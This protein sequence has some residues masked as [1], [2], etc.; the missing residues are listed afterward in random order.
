MTE[1]ELTYSYVVKNSTEAIFNFYRQGYLYYRIVVK[2]GHDDER[3]YVF[4][5]E[6]SDLGTATTSLSEKPLTMMRYIRKSLED[7]TFVRSM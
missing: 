2:F 5:V 6:V 4:P 3:P 1:K 7:G